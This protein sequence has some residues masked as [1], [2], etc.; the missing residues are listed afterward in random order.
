[1]TLKSFTFSFSFILVSNVD[2]SN[3][4]HNLDNKMDIPIY[5]LISLNI[6]NGQHTQSNK[7][8]CL[9]TNVQTNGR[10]SPPLLLDW[11]KQRYS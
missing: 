10:F 4:K 7:D 2:I 8:Y 1:M 6:F 3:S 5:G 11:I 9:I